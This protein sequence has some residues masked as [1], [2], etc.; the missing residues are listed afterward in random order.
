MLTAVCVFLWW[1]GG[2]GARKRARILNFLRFRLTQPLSLDIRF[3]GDDKARVM[4]NVRAVDRFTCERFE[5]VSCDDAL[6]T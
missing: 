2:K 4:R 5:R 6:T 1:A 3:C